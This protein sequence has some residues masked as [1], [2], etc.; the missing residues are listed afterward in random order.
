[1]TEM[2]VRAPSFEFPAPVKPIGTLLDVATVQEGIAWLEP[3]GLAESFNCL[4]LDSVPVWPCPAVTLAAPTSTAA[5]TATTG[6]TLTAGTYRAVIT[7]VNSRGET[8]ASTEQSRVTTGSTSTI[9]WNW[10]AV[11]GATAYKVYIT[12]V[13]GATGTATYA[14]TVTAPT[15]TYVQTAPRTAGGAAPPTTNTAITVASKTF[16]SP[17]WQ[18][19]FRFG[20]Y[21]GIKCKGPGFDMV[22]A[23]G[24]VRA[25]FEASESVGVERALMTTRFVDGAAWDPATDLTPAGGAVSASI[26]LALLEGDAAGKYAGTPIIHAPRAVASLLSTI[27]AGLDREG[28]RLVSKLGTPIAAGGGYACPNAGPTGAA[29]AAGEAWMYAS[30]QVTVARGEL[31]VKSDIDRVEN[32]VYVLAERAYVA[33]VDCYTAAVRVKVS[34]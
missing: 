4:I 28:N 15:V 24:K 25:A 18:D 5:G 14:A 16:E 22:E 20:V 21:G 23:E 17:T 12:A 9:T 7:A 13:G 26:G 27:G 34:T 11:T 30:G 31:L 33:A 29:P 32:D 1:M 3:T 6:G 8:I 19:G 10:N 2:L